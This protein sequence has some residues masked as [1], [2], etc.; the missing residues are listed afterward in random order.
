M[1][2]VLRWVYLMCIQKNNTVT[3]KIFCTWCFPIRWVISFKL[4]IKL[5]RHLKL[6]GFVMLIMSRMH[7]HQLWESLEVPLQI[8]LHV[9][10]QESVLYGGHIM[11]GLIRLYSLCWN[12]Y[13]KKERLLNKWLIKLRIKI[14][15]SDWWV[16][17]IESIRTLIQEQKLC[18]RCVMKF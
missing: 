16:L 5:L 14:A 7:Q 10:Q 12:K 1:H 13:T 15:N 17:G 6:F 8:L 9:L 18:R 3:W 2:I 11:E 4:L